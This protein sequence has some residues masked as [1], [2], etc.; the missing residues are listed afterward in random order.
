M[1]LH[2]LADQVIV[3][4]G[5]EAFSLAGRG[6]QD[7]RLRPGVNK[8]VEQDP[9][10]GVGEEC[11]DPLARLDLIELIGAK[12]VEE[13]GPLAA[14]DF[15]LG[16][17]WRPEKPRPWRKARYSAS[18]SPKSTATG[19]QGVSRRT[20]PLSRRMSTIP[21]ESFHRKSTFL[22]QSKLTASKTG[23]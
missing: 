13:F 21:V 16:D 4:V 23:R 22:Q 19:P 11:L 2:I 6:V 14:G 18:Q 12:P 8:H 1:E 17:T 10:V 20:A 5:T 9:A 7:Q 3:Q 15:D